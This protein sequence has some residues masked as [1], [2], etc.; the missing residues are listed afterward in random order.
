MN[1]RVLSLPKFDRQAKRLIKKFPSLKAEILNLVHSLIQNPAQGTKIARDCYK[2]R[3]SISSK[4]KG[5]SGG[6]RII[7]HVL[8]KDHSV[9]LLLIYDKSEQSGVSDSEIEELLQE[10]P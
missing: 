3:I 1:F 8:I 4:G 2:I 6:A 10:I 7:T 5:K 9:Y